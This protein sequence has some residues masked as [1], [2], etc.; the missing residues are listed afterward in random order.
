MNVK[1]RE[2]FICKRMTKPKLS[3]HVILYD[4]KRSIFGKWHWV[5]EDKKI[6]IC[7]KCLETASALVRHNIAIKTSDIVGD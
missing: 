7:S 4:A 3:T 1:K 6:F 5:G 2:C